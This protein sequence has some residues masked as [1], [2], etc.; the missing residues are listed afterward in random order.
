MEV[1]IHKDEG[2]AEI[3]Q[4]VGMRFAFAVLE[5]KGTKL[6]LRQVHPF[7]KC[8][9]FLG[10]AMYAAQNGSMYN[11]YSFKFDGSKQSLC[12]D[13]THMFIEFDNEEA[14]NKNLRVMHYY[15]AK[16]KWFRT[17]V[18]KLDVKSPTNKPVF[19][20]VSSKNW[21]D[22]TVLISLY[23]LLWRLAGI[24]IKDDESVPDFVRRCSGHNSND[25]RYLK[26]VLTVADKFEMK[27]PLDYVMSN[28]KKIFIPQYGV[29]STDINRIHYHNG[30]ES[31]MKE[32]SSAKSENLGINNEDKLYGRSWAR[33]LVALVGN[34]KTQ[35][36]K[37]KK[38]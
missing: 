17:K 28:R 16:C 19:Y 29:K 36:K 22:S 6:R 20:A 30:I 33:N 34:A 37:E 1:T 35:P 26:T 25:G 31:F 15:E 24:G 27:S 9:D 14:L 23:T 21:M 11:L 5:G 4:Q 8:R 38:E 18:V 32:A 7:V 3:Y 2:L 13:R 12:F 10:D